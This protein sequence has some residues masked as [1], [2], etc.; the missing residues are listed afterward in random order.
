MRA[1]AEGEGLRCEIGEVEE[2]QMAV[3]EVQGQE[4]V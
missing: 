4:V 2:V 1:Q 3:D